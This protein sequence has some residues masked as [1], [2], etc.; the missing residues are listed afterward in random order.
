MDRDRRQVVIVQ[1]GSSKLGFGQVEAQRLDQMQLAAGGRRGPDG[2]AR[3]GGDARSNEQ[4]LNMTP[5][6]SFDQQE[7]QDIRKVGDARGPDRRARSSIQARS[8]EATAA[9]VLAYQLA[10]PFKWSGMCGPH[11]RESVR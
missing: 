7:Q 8:T 4:S 6:K 11:R 3:V 10:F 9:S 5:S 2:V 1:F